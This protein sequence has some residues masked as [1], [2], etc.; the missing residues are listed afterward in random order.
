MLNKFVAISCLLIT[1]T[2]A[3]AA[4]ANVIYLTRQGEK[5]ASGSDPALTEQ[6]Q[7]RA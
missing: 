7:L 1:G 6:G 4:D 2:V 3:M 5:Q